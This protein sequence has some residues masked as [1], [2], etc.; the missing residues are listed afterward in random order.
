[1]KYRIVYN[2]TIT[3]FRHVNFVAPLI[4][5]VIILC[6]ST[7]HVLLCFKQSRK[8]VFVLGNEFLLHDWVLVWAL[9]LGV[10]PGKPARC[11]T[12][13]QTG[14][15]VFKSL[16]TVCLL[17]STPFLSSL[18][19][20]NWHCPFIRSCTSYSFCPF[21]ALITCI[22]L[23]TISR[24]IWTIY[25]LILTLLSRV[26]RLRTVPPLRYFTLRF[27]KSLLLPTAGQFFTCLRTPTD[28]R[29]VS[30]DS[31]K[32]TNGHVHHRVPIQ[33]GRWFSRN[34]RGVRVLGAGWGISPMS[35][36]FFQ[37]T[38]ITSTTVTSLCYLTNPLRVSTRWKRQEKPTQTKKIMK[39]L[40]EFNEVDR[41]ES[42]RV[43]LTWLPSR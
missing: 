14:L 9:E 3:V 35:F 33:L 20:Y 5:W 18:D 41:S 27:C 12:G 10:P 37:P 26:S 17:F 39:P 32:G 38:H 11:V 8:R 19:S 21:V 2:K 43:I 28:F 25:F 7:L 16:Y 13:L 34:S 31:S 15:F 4:T 6:S 22:Q 40:N 24:I 23:K 30:D 36:L 29:S 1:M 42:L